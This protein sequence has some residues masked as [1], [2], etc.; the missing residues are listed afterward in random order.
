MRISN[1][2]CALLLTGLL[3]LQFS[4]VSIA[5]AFAD[6]SDTQSLTDISS[7]AEQF[8]LAAVDASIYTDLEVQAQALDPRL[9]LKQCEVPL[10]AFSNNAVL[11]AGRTTIGVRCDG[12]SPWSLYVPVNI[13]ANVAVVMIKGPVTRGTIL[14]AANLQLVHIPVAQLP[15]NYVSNIDQVN[16][17]ELARAINRN[18]FATA[19]MLKQQN[20][21]QKGQT[22]II[23]AQSAGFEVRM[24]GTALENGQRGERISVKNTNSG[25]TV[26]GEVIAE[27]LIAVSL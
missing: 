1:T 10:Q 14:S 25:R 19:A 3:G 12:A 21:I 16:G 18:T 7:T 20:M 22:V 24:G 5:P 4:P 2:T 23:L 13:N 11:K 9:R 8:A 27:N 15:P 17:R 6:E 26:E